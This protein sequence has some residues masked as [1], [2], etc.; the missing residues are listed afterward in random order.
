MLKEKNLL[1]LFAEAA[2]RPVPY[3]GLASIQPN[4]DIARANISPS[5]RAQNLALF[6]QVVEG[7]EQRFRE[8]R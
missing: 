3:E 4:M 7:A 2:Q 8:I 6:L 5:Q 1:E